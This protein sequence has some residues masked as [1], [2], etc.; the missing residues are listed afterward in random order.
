MDYSLDQLTDC[1]SQMLSY[2][3]LIRV[4]IEN[5]RSDHSAFKTQDL[6]LARI[7]KIMKLDDDIK[8]MMISAEAPILFAKAAELFIRELTLRAWIHTER[9]RRR[10]LQRNDIAMA[11]SDGDT[12]Q[13]DFLIDIVPREEVR[14]HRRPHSSST[15]TNQNINVPSSVTVKSENTTGS[16]P[17]TTANGRISTHSISTLPTDASAAT[18]H[19]QAVTITLG[20]TATSAAGTPD[21]VDNTTVVQPSQT[22]TIQFATA[23]TAVQSTAA[24]VT[25]QATTTNNN[26]SLSSSTTATVATTTTAPAVAPIQYVLQLPVGAGGAAAGQPFQIQLLPQHF[27]SSSTDAMS[28][29]TVAGQT[30]T[31]LTDVNGNSVPVVQVV[32]QG[33]AGL[34]LPTILQDSNGQRTQILQLQRPTLLLQPSDSMLGATAVLTSNSTDGVNGQ[35]Q[36][37]AYA[38]HHPQQIIQ[39]DVTSEAD[40]SAQLLLT[41]ADHTACVEEPENEPDPNMETVETINDVEAGPEESHI[42]EEETVTSENFAD[43][44]QTYPTED[45]VN[46]NQITDNDQLRDSERTSNAENVVE[47][48]Q[49][50]APENDTDLG[51]VDSVV[52]DGEPVD[53]NQPELATSVD[54]MTVEDQS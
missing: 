9:N 7:K 33:A 1:Q 51:E 49:L 20:G 45:S 19:P 32:S 10:T 36:H 15:I 3:E 28:S 35:E 47:E 44:V 12:D 2:W 13:F 54:T 23:P 8:T 5:I 46:S 18:T 17:F 21:V 50:S 31:L 4:E 16:S 11:V 34:A 26:N 27:Q 25:G 14:G 24:L 40:Q 37:I 30:G 41:F 6:P 38:L 42:V 22:P 53:D 43:V 52:G 29:P 48:L 39:A